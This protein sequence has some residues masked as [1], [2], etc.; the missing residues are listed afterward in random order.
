MDATAGDHGESSTVKAKESLA[1]LVMQESMCR[2]VWAYA[3]ESKG[4][5]EE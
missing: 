3:V 2:S 4:A 1:I 5:K